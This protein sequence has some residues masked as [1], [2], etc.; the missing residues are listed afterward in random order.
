ML[1]IPW[2]QRSSN[3]KFVIIGSGYGGSIMAARL[4]IALQQQHSVCM[5]ERGKEWKVGEFPSDV[6][7][8]LAHTRSDLNPLGLYEFL[9][10]KDISVIKGSGLGGTSL[11]NANVAIVP[12]GEVFARAGWPAD[13]QYQDMQ[14]YYDRARKVLA[15]APVPDGVNLLKVKALEK[16]AQQL[17][18]HAEALNLAVNFQFDGPNVHGVLGCEP[19]TSVSCANCAVIRVSPQES[20]IANGTCE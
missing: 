8:I 11:I 12:D 7:G 15:V 6:P 9:V 16:R 5:L 3:Y 20:S 2:E 1:A 13:I 10:Y 4:A 14:Q 17:G 18:Q 19:H